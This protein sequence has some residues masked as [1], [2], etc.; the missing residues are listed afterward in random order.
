MMSNK[1]KKRKLAIITTSRAEYGYF[2]PIIREIEKRP[3]LDYGVIATDMHV[4]DRFGHSVDEMQKDRVKM[5]GSVFNTFDGYT[6][7]TMVKSLSVFML[8][9]PEIIEQM[10]ADM[11]IVNGDR[12]AQLVAAV[13]GAYLYKPV[14]HVQ[15]GEV[16]GNIDGVSRHAMTRFA[17]LHFAS[18]KDAA[19]RVRKM[20]EEPFR[21]HTVGAPQLDDFVAGNITSRKAL[22]KKFHLDPQ[23]KT[24]LVMRHSV[25]ED[26]DAT[27][28]H[29]EQTLKA[30]SHFNDANIIVFLNNSDAGSNLLRR[31]IEHNRTS[32]M[33][34][35]SNVPRVDFGGLMNVADVLVGNSSA[36]ILEAP[37][38]TLPAVNIGRR[39][40][41]RLRGINVIDVEEDTDDIILGIR[42]ALSPQFRAKMK[43]CVNPY[44]DGKSS[45]RI[46]DILAS[47]PIDEKLLVK[48]LTY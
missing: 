7:L 26:F 29:M 19:E 2:L 41:G 28:K 5:V 16:S 18:N 46:V 32:A 48:H 22:V 39:E 43:K 42:K 30:V 14:A 45:K 34:V 31:A 13:V 11:V 17:H 8:Q 3:A 24:I 38:F 23:K 20:G 44:G 15:S 9:L 47:V 4:L 35:F 40:Y 37:T 25:T 27:E 10:G 12:G 6:H 33:Q 1:K 36:G 21:I